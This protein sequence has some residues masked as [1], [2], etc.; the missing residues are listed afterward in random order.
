LRDTT[1]RPIADEGELASATVRRG[2][3][4]SRVGFYVLAAFFAAFA[5]FPMVWI[6]D[7]S[8]KPLNQVTAQ[9][10]TYIPWPPTL[11]NYQVAFGQAPF[12]RYYLSSAIVSVISTL[13]CLVLAALAGYAIARLRFRGKQVVLIG[14]LMFSFFPAIT[15][16]V[17]LY[18]VMR[19]LNLLNTYP[20]LIIPYTFHSL[21]MAIWLLSAYLRDIP[22]DL[23]EA[24]MVDGT[25]RLGAFVRVILPVSAPGFVTSGVI[26]FVWCWNEFLL[27]LAF[28]TET[29]VKT[30]PVGIQQYQGQFTFPWG[31]ISA[32]TVL[33]VIP[34]VLLILIFQRRLITG[35]TAGAVK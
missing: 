29:N 35:L 34:L 33:A 4:P 7:T 30:L 5:F 25:T 21:P 22:R 17:P 8:F 15:Q 20:A 9:P 2:I 14:V 27:A 19:T 28:M 13:C 32:A 11:E 24:A 12:A 16:L 31:T 3:S 6:L 23:E 1:L 26:V 10:V 18:N